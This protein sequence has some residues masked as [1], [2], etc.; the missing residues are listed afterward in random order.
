MK[1]SKFLRKRLLSTPSGITLTTLAVTIIVMLILAGVTI[2][3]AVGDT[4]L[5]NSATN[6]RAESRKA[7]ELDIIKSAYASLLLKDAMSD[8]GVT[9]DNL[10]AEI[11]NKGLNCID[12]K[13]I[14]NNQDEK[15]GWWEVYINSEDCINIYYINPE[16][17]K[18][19][20]G[21]R[22]DKSDFIK[23]NIKIV[24]E[25]STT[26]FTKEN[27]TAKISLEGLDTDKYTMYYR[28]GNDTETKYTG[29]ITIDANTTLYAYANHNT[30]S[31]VKVTASS[32]IKNIDK[33]PP[34]SVSFTETHTTN[35]IKVTANAEDAPETDTY[36][37][38]GIKAYRFKEGENNWT[39]WKESNEYE[40]TGLRQATNYN[41]KVEAMDNAGNT[42]DVTSAVTTNSIKGTI[43][44]GTPTWNGTTATVTFST[45]SGFYIQ[46]K[47][48]NGNWSANPESI[49]SATASATTGT[50]IYARLTDKLG[51]TTAESAY[52]SITP[53]LTYTV[54]YDGNGATGGSTVSSAHNYGTAK[55]LTKNGFTKTGYKFTGWNTKA[56]GTGT[57]Y[58]DSQSVTNLSSVNGSTVTLY[59]QWKID[60]K[61]PPTVILKSTATDGFTIGFSDSSGVS[62]VG[63]TT[64]NSVPTAYNG[65]IDNG[66]L[67]GDFGKIIGV[68]YVYYDDNDTAF[69]LSASGLNS[70]TTYYV[71]G[72]DCYGNVS[73]GLKVTTAKMG[74]VTISAPYYDGTNSVVDIT[75]TG[76]GDLYYTTGTSST[77][78]SWTKASGTTAK[79]TV[80]P[81]TTVRAVL[82]D[83]TNAG[84]ASSKS[85]SAVVGYWSMFN[86]PEVDSPDDYA[87]FGE[88]VEKGV[89]S[90]LP[91]T[92]YLVVY[93]DIYET[94]FGKQL[95]DVRDL[96]IYADS[97]G[98][99]LNID[100]LDLGKNT[101]LYFGNY[102]TSYRLDLYFS[103]C[104]SMYDN[105]YLNINYATLY[106]QDGIYGNQNSGGSMPRI[107]IDEPG[108]IYASCIV[109]IEKNCQY[110]WK[111]EG[112]T[113]YGYHYYTQKTTYTITYNANGGTGAPSSQTKTYGTNLTLS[114]TK[115]TRTGY[116]FLG[117]STSSTATAATYSAGGTYSTEASV[118]LYAVWSK[119]LSTVIVNS[120]GGTAKVSIKGESSAI[121]TTTGT[122]K[123]AYGAELYLEVPTRAGYIFTGWKKSSSFNGTLSSSTTSISTYIWGPAS[124]TT[125]TITATWANTVTLSAT[126]C[127][128]K[129]SS[130]TTVSSVSVPTG[131]TYSASGNVLT[132]NGTKYTATANSEVGYSFSTPTWSSSSGTITS[133][134]TLTASSTKTANTYKLTLNNQGAT[135][136]GT[137]EVYDL[138]MNAYFLDAN[139]NSMMGTSMNPITPPT[140]TGC[141]F[142]GYY[143]GTNGT[144]SQCIQSTGKLNGSAPHFAQNTTLYA[145]WTLNSTA[146]IWPYESVSE[147]AGSM[148]DDDEYVYGT[149]KVNG[150]D[151]KFSEPHT[152][153]D[154]TVLD[155]NKK[156]LFKINNGSSAERSLSSGTYKIIWEDAYGYYSASNGELEFTVLNSNWENGN[157]TYFSN[158]TSSS[159]LSSSE[160]TATG[161]FKYLMVEN[162]S[163]QS[164]GFRSLTLSK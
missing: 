153:N 8:K 42:K 131:S 112:D 17:G 136:A 107:Y 1:K 144:G 46:T 71:W 4:G 60:D 158:R 156:Y 114:S 75:K 87:T 147:Y 29:E 159:S 149:Y 137:T 108:E 64:S 52:V 41:I 30:Y 28:K 53:I 152:Y 146:M 161:S 151:Y 59:A 81:G 104:I 48:G 21:D 95:D 111:E 72:M 65:N 143:T 67:T 31:N 27:V 120:N 68:W 102:D 101:Y 47:V 122:W 90:S 148:L 56:D 79:P 57:A 84:T 69:E 55:T 142:G 123:R 88:A 12:V 3:V 20:F 130:G 23:K 115:P 92:Q 119:N 85:V 18:V 74:T 2:K 98:L 61:T 50:T 93:E 83:G 133:A 117:W 150:T 26:E 76:N 25:L 106:C 63:I 128:I 66:P 140:K 7:E 22:E 32:T 16:D 132:L 127:T 99:Q 94:S 116:T 91:Y 33:L 13:K 77:I 38:S 73:S 24:I 15:N 100:Y 45:L 121:I 126:N 145:Y 135:T 97:N 163:T 96:E 6:A 103:S 35:S 44:V 157:L 110:Q 78:S 14:D 89:Q 160:I 40:F 134:I 164:R 118:T 124:D 105:S 141:T 80:K 11:N 39:D 155:A 34:S 62:Y 70:N 54:A 154:A 125:D 51:Q 86:G 162:T 58:T 10:K 113:I 19:T 36:A 43:I 9:E 138:Y 82:Y 37:R 49:G 129:N 109:D 5:I 139:H